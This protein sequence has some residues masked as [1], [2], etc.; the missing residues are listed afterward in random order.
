MGMGHGIEREKGADK[1]R[2]EEGR[3]NVRGKGRKASG[4][5]H[6][7]ERGCAPCHLSLIHI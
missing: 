1:E 3:G 6:L 4:P 7:S 2:G 5:P